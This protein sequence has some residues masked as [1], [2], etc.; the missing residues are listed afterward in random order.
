M[1]HL[2]A[3]LGLVVAA[4]WPANAQQVNLKISDGRV[5]LD[6]TNV[7]TRVIL[8]EWARIGGTK[9]VGAEKIGGVPLTLKLVDMPERQALDIILRNVAGFIAAPRRVADAN[10]SSYDRILIMASSTVAPP[11]APAAN[12]G[13]PGAGAPGMNGNQG[14]AMNGLQRFIPPRPPNLPPSPAED[15]DAD[16][17]DPTDTA[18]TG[19][20]QPVFTF[21]SPQGAPANGQPTFVP[22]QPSGGNTQTQFGTFGQATPGMAPTITL[23]PG[24]NGPT[25]YNFTPN[26]QV[27]QPP[28]PP[29]TP[30]TPFG[31]T[32]SPRPG[33][34][35]LPPP[36]TP[37]QPAAPV[38][39][40]PGQN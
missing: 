23:Q 21:P 27:N 13:R 34:I 28:A 40:P 18:D 16:A 11:A 38:T 22:M 15:A 2:I 26:G 7:P 9:I 19:V 6:A 32:G 5:S 14:N 29:T 12:A 1:K 36:N 4:A 10:A 39:R 20:T 37:G 25:I 35:Q 3:A 30:T 17:D 8:A 24:A 33:I 31:A